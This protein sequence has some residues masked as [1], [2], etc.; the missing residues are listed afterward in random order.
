MEISIENVTLTFG[1]ESILSNLTLKLKGPRL[2]QIIGPNGAGKTTL[3]KVILGLVKPDSGRVLINGRDVTG[4]PSRVGPLVG[5]VPQITP[6][7]RIYPVTAWEVVFNSLLIHEN[8]WPRLFATKDEIDR[9]KKVLEEVELPRDRWNKCFW[10][11]SGGERQR[12]LLARTMVYE[13]EILLLDEPLSSVDPL[14]KVELAKLIGD[15]AEKK[16][17]I[18]TSHDPV[19]LLPYTDLIAL[20]NRSYFI[21]GKPEEVLRLEILRNAYGESAV[22][23]EEHVHISDSH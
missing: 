22:L 1:G 5:Y 17:V 19:L 11:L 9:T 4:K 8:R 20:L 7:D 2:V 16:L 3:F 14:G 15:I 23:L 12:V 21:I 6:L 10:E 18:V 13:P